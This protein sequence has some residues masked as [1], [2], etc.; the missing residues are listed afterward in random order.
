MK[1]WTHAGIGR[2][3]GLN[4]STV[5]DKIREGTLPARKAEANH[6]GRI[7]A[8]SK[9]LDEWLGKHHALEVWLGSWKLGFLD[10]VQE[11]PARKT[12]D[13]DYIAGYESGRRSF[14]NELK[15]YRDEKSSQYEA[16]KKHIQKT[17][18]ARR[19]K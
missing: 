6:N 19:K 3:L 1:I 4:P 11:K 13:L 14:E 8:E 15:A 10:A 17:I 5:K 2:Y 12:Y 9:D 16:K 18:L 7:W